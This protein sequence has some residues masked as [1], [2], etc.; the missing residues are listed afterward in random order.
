MERLSLET[1]WLSKRAVRCFI[2]IMQSPLPQNEG[3]IVG[4]PN[5]VAV[6][7]SCGP[8]MFQGTNVAQ[9]L[10]KLWKT[11][12][13]CDAHGPSDQVGKPKTE[14]TAIDPA[15]RLARVFSA[16]LSTACRYEYQGA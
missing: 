12:S 11:R 15:A 4:N 7:V 1:C 10:T 16:D 3:S 5:C 8:D 2:Q 13:P 9:V 6:S 14:T